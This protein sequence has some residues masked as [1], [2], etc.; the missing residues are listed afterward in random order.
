MGYANFFVKP[1]IAALAKHIPEFEELIENINFNLSQWK[2][3]TADG[4][5]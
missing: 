2:N 5:G 1:Y 3:L 4:D